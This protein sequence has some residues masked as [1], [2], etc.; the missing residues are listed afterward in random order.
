MVRTGNKATMV[1]ATN[2]TDGTAYNFRNDLVIP[3]KIQKER[4]IIVSESAND[5][6]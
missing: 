1:T 6:E 2:R 5:N 4:K 3:E